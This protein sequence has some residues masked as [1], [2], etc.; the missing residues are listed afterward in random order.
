[1]YLYICFLQIWISGR[2]TNDSRFTRQSTAERGSSLNFPKVVLVVC[3]LISNF[4][5][6]NPRLQVMQPF[7][8]WLLSKFIPYVVLRIFPAVAISGLFIRDLS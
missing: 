4:F 3:L 7:W 2:A 8:F 5:K 6:P 1:M